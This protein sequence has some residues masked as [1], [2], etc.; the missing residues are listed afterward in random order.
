MLQKYMQKPSDQND[1]ELR[2]DYDLSRMTIVARGRYA[3]H[4]RLGNKVVL[5]APDVVQAF[6]TDEG[7]NEALRL[8]M[9]IAETPA[10]GNRAGVIPTATSLPMRPPRLPPAQLNRTRRR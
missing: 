3:S 5:L 6:P 8:V 10:R 9:Q 2:D 1:Y 4:R 7:V